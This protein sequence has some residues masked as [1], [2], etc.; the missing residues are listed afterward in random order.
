MPQPIH[1]STPPQPPEKIK[2][3]TTLRE[4]QVITWKSATPD[5]DI[6]RAYVEDK[7]SQRVDR[8]NQTEEHLD[9]GFQGG[10]GDEESGET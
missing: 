2:F 1:R 3:V 4:L 8:G 6:G 10:S 5:R 7:S 9:D